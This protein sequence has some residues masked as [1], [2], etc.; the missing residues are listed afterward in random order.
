MA[1]DKITIGDLI[2]ELEQYALDT[3]VR[4]AVQPIWPMEM[5]LAGTCMGPEA[6]YLVM[7]EQIGYLPAEVSEQLSWPDR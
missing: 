2:A 7:G 4:L 6:L 5:T 1:Q 3:E